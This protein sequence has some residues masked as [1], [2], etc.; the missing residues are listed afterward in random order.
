MTIAVDIGELELAW[1]RFKRDL[2][3]RYF[4]VHPRL[5]KWIEID[6][7][8]W[9]GEVSTQI[10]TGY[11]PRPSRFCAVPKAKHLIRPAS[12]LEPEDAVVYN[13][14]V[15]R[16][17]PRIVSHLKSW[18]EPPDAAYLLGSSD[19]AEWT[20]MGFLIWQRWRERSIAHLKPADIEYVVATD[21]TGF[22]ENI[23]L[24][25]L[26]S[27]LRAIGAD[28][29]VVDLLQRCLRNWALPR[30]EGLPQGYS[31][32]DILAKLYLDSIDRYLRTD[33][34]AHTR[35]VDDLRVFCRSKL[36]GKR[37]N[38]PA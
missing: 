20:N 30:N 25:K 7:P 8:S 17:F 10:Q 36:D 29:E 33:G 3:D 24:Q 37:A 31:A 34:F 19:S 15:G 16:T 26:A 28:T 21:I 9:L 5:V 22:Y 23:D 27:D 2:Q 12:I 32:S 18:S 13:F 11:A 1:K 35:Y 6:L 38:P 4:I 14:A